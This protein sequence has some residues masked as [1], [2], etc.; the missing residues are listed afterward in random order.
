VPNNML[1]ASKYFAAG[2]YDNGVFY[3]LTTKGRSLRIGIRCQTTADMYWSIFDNFRLYFYGSMSYSDLTAIKDIATE[4]TTAKGGANCIYSIDGRIVRK[5]ST[6]LEGLPR[7]LY[8]VNGKK[9]AKL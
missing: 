3:E 7:G 9:V 4:S 1:A 5:G 6:S 8:I 2:L